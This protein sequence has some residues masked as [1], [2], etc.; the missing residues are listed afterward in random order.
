MCTHLWLTVS[1]NFSL[2]SEQISG[3]I[4]CLSQ[5]LKSNHMLYAKN[6]DKKYAKA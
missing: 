1:A 5:I 2:P 3:Q 4:Y 6:K